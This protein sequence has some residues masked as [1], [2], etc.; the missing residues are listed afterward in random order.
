[1]SAFHLVR[2]RGPQP[3]DTWVLQPE[4]K[5]LVGRWGPDQDGLDIDLRPDR[6]VS[7]AHAHIWFQDNVW[8]IED[9]NS[10][11]GTLVGGL[12]IKGAGPVPLAPG[13]EVQVG[14]TVLA[15]APAPAGDLG[16]EDLALED[17]GQ[18][19]QVV[20]ASAPPFVVRDEGDL[21][22]RLAQAQ[23]QLKALYDLSEAQGTAATPERL[24]QIL[25]EQ[26]PRAI[27]P[28]QRGA[29]VLRGDRG[30]LLLKAHWPPGKPS[31][32]TTWVERAWEKRE[33]F[34][35]T[36]PPEG[37]DL[38]ESVMHYQ[39][40]AA[41]YAP[42]IW[43][44]EVL[45]LVYVDNHD[46]REAFTPADLELMRAIANQAA[47]F[48][49]THAL[50]Q[51]LL[52][53]E[54]IRANLLRQFPPKLAERLM[55][56]RGR[57]RLGGERADPVTI[58]VSDVRGFTAL[59]AAMQPDDVVQMLNEMFGVFIPIIF[60]NDGTVDKYVG[61]ALLAVFGSPQ[62]D[63]RQW[64]KAVRAA[65]EM[66]QAMQKLGEVWRMRG[67]PVCEVGIG[68][69]TGEAVHG[70]IGS[71]ERMEYTVIGD[72]VNR[73]SR[74]CDGAG[75]GEVLISKG[76]YE[77]VYRLVE[78]VPATIKTKHPETEPDLEG[79]LVKRLKGA[80]A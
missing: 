13:V 59:S 36:A 10:R 58:L 15:L 22:E 9:L 64:E 7:R 26:L 29:V 44:G 38:S 40:Q 19:S 33:A 5:N 14:D 45:G 28:A 55:T 12:E 53:E 39:V 31:V 67:L 4:R 77:R 35:W 20:A 41:I 37:G 56:E 72:T 54:G 46:S 25:A 43:E 69:N 47:M 34:V 21:N 48:I 11:N 66:Q 30:E 80:A 32:S 3:R 1:M 78:V 18:I 42:L 63:D 70:F 49:K 61:D 16:I 27:R 62:P 68:V 73:A 65:L 52:R 23:A 51:A 76:V 60:K 75:R 79:Y 6:D 17:R 57:L 2:V 50:Q 74:Y 71:P 8:W 24:F